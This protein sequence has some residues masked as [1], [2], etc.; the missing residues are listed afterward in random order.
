MKYK[1]VLYKVN[2]NSAKIR[3][4]RLIS[5]NKILWNRWQSLSSNC[6]PP[7]DGIFPKWQLLE[8]F[9]ASFHPG[10][11]DRA[12]ESHL[13]SS[14]TQPQQSRW[15]SDEHRPTLAAKW[16]TR[17]DSLGTTTRQAGAHPHSDVGLDKW[18]LAIKSIR[19]D[20]A[21]SCWRDATRHVTLRGL[22]IYALPRAIAILSR[23]E[24]GT[25]SP[26][27]RGSRYTPCLPLSS[28]TFWLAGACGVDLLTR[29]L[30]RARSSQSWFP[31]IIDRYVHSAINRRDYSLGS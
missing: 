21:L 24:A 5:S 20:M 29:Q 31:L 13:S 23:G 19:R 11:Q 18:R 4:L 16:R 25:G 14:G 8:N 2:N 27:H 9:S 17:S 10:W 15:R 12:M 28:T 3:N 7:S 22:A 1:N 26:F 30:S 6:H